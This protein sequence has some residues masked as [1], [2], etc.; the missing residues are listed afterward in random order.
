MDH[1]TQEE[2]QT[3]ERLGSLQ[4]TLWLQWRQMDAAWQNHNPADSNVD[5][6]VLARLGATVALLMSCGFGGCHTSRSRME[7]DRGIQP[8]I[9]MLHRPLRFSL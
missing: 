9:G 5:I 6:D 1:K 4:E 3:I 7:A 8:H 2:L